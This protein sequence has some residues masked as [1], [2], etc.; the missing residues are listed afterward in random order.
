M[1]APPPITIEAF[2]RHIRQRYFETDNARGTAAT[3]LWFMEEV[4]E[5]AT[6]LGNASKEAETGDESDA[7]R[8]LRANL[9]EEFADVMA[10][11]MTLANINGVDLPEVIRRKYLESGGPSGHK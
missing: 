1:D 9:E 6:A 5:L 8:A 10:W 2:Q 4:G 11:L 3:F 7:T